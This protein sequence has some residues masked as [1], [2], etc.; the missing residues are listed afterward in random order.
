M[1]VEVDKAFYGSDRLV[2]GY[3]GIYSQDTSTIIDGEES[4]LFEM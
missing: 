4:M 2:N 1:Y 3:L